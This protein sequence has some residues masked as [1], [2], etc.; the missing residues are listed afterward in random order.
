M[1]APQ[2]RTCRFLFG[3]NRLMLS[4]SWG[5]RRAGCNWLRSRYDHHMHR[6]QELGVYWLA[7]DKCRGW[8]WRDLFPRTSFYGDSSRAFW[9]AAGGDVLIGAEAVDW[10]PNASRLLITPLS[11]PR[12]VP[13]ARRPRRRFRHG[14]D[15]RSRSFSHVTDN[16]LFRTSFKLLRHFCRL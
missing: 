11:P 3:G 6:E 10:D 2:L 9:E 12:F 4:S 7:D 15:D 8:N 5:N 14:I 13:G 16:I 1:D